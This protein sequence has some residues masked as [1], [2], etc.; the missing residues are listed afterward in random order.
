MNA[1]IRAQVTGCLLRQNCA[2]DN[3]YSKSIRD[4]FRLPSI[5]HGYN[6]HNLSKTKGGV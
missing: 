1:Y 3:C 2:E 6:S 5:R 4:R